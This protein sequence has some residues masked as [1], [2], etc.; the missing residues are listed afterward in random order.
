[1]ARFGALPA[2]RLGQAVGLTSGA[3]TIAV[4]RLERAGYVE[5]RHDPA[6][7]RRV[8]VALA[9][10]AERVVAL[11]A[12]LRAPTERA[13]GAYS[14]AELALLDTFLHHASQTLQELAA[15]IRQRPRSQT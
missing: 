7:R 4:D 10:A 11:F 9:P 12:E 3:L 2:G 13:L 5:R 1:L 6:D 15:S 8:L 14:E